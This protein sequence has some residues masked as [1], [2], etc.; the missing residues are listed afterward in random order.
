LELNQGERARQ[1]QASRNHDADRLR[2]GE[3]SPAELRDENNFF[4]SLNLPSFE[5]AAVAA[6]DPALALSRKGS[7]GLRF[8]LTSDLRHLA[9]EQCARSLEIVQD[10]DAIVVGGQSVNL[11]AEHYARRH[12]KVAAYGRFTVSDVRPPPSSLA[13][14]A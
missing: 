6:S 1:K 12:S 11:W 9:A 5:I 2:R 7:G 3:I 14:E 4:P 10:F 8:P 13:A